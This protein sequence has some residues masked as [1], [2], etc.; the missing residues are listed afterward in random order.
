MIVPPPV[1]AGGTIGVVAPGGAVQAGRAR[2]RR[3]AGSRRWGFACA[4]ASTCWRGVATSPAT[5][6]LRLA[7]LERMLRDPEVGA[8]ICARGGYGT[9]QLLPLLDPALVVDAS[10]AR[11][12]LQRRVAVARLRGRAL[13]RRRAARPD[14]RDR[15]RQGSDGASRGAALRAP[16]GP[17]DAPGGSR[18][19]DVVRRAS[20]RAGSS[21]AVSRRWSRCS[22]RRT[23]SRPTAPCSSSRTSPSGR[24][25]STAC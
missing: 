11:R 6:E 14:G 22:A 16:G 8:V 15:P 7:D 21:A 20:R 24:T 4:S 1:V 3:R 9:T 5:P 19:R 17:D 25:A 23:P 12:R 18:S 13:R 2:A 10:E